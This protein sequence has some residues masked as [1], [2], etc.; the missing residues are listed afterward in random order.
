[1]QIDL[2]SNVLRIEFEKKV[3]IEED[4]YEK[5]FWTKFQT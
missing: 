3:I 2:N 5:V 1:M 4:L